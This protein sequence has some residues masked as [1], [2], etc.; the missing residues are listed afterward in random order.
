MLIHV[1]RSQLTDSALRDA[2]HMELDSAGYIRMPARFQTFCCGQLALGS[3][4][5]E[6]FEAGAEASK[7]TGPNKVNEADR[8]VSGIANVESISR[9]G[10]KIHLDGLDLT[11]Y[12]QNPIVLA[13]H[14]AFA[15]STL[16][17]G[18]I[19]TVEKVFK[20]RQ[21]SELRFRNLKFDTDPIA[22]AWY[23]KVLCGT[24]RMVSV[25]FLPLEWTFVS[26][27]V[28]KGKDK[29]EIS[30][31]DIPKS[32]LLEISV[33][34]IGANRGAFI[35]QTPPYQ[36]LERISR[37]EQRAAELQKALEAFVASTKQSAAD[38]A[39]ERLLNAVKQFGG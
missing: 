24:V 1:P 25:G 3:E 26:E 11:S 20:A 19:G 9:S 8:T 5:A 38:A 32:E 34:P 28:G 30:Y 16:M 36:L 23:Q 31:I 39:R 29:R 17:P 2:F 4:L 6:A 14:S 13:A 35:G 18:A 7:T 10:I 21:A 33:V 27:T 15:Y 12:H 37:A 22:E